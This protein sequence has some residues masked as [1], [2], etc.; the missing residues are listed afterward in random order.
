[1][2]MMLPFVTGTLAVWFGLVGRRRPCVTF[3]LLT[4]VNFAAWF[5]YHMTSPLALSL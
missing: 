5:N 1:M 4:L 2:V 3:W